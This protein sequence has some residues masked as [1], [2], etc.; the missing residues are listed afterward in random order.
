MTAA[1]SQAHERF[2]S[3][4]ELLV[5]SKMDSSTF[6]DEMRPLL[7]ANAY[8]TFTLDKL[9]QKLVKQLQVLMTVCLVTSIP[10]TAPC[11]APVKVCFSLLTG[12][13]ADCRF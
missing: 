10:R 4:V 8:V 12:A 13:A 11:D 9:L 3:T 7:G 6:E 1:F 5:S 2:L